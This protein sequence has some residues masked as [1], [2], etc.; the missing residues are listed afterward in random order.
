[1]NELISDP[2]ELEIVPEAPKASEA[3][4]NKTDSSLI[5]EAAQVRQASI[6]VA[7][8]IQPSPRWGIN[9]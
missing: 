6:P 3:V 4:L 1:M 8:E 9:E 2:A 5:S 7:Q